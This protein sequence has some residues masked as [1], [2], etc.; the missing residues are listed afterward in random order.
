VRSESQV[1]AEPEPPAAP[2]PVI[3]RELRAGD[4]EAIADLHRR[5]Y[6]PEFGTNEMFVEGVAAAARSARAAGWPERGGGVWLVEHRGEL[7]GSL[8]LIAQPGDLGRV[9]WFVVHPALRGRGLGARMVAELV[10]LARAQDMRE[11]ELETFSELSAAARIY[12]G[13][14]FRVVAERPRDDWGKPMSYQRYHLR[15]S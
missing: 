8:A 7:G 12:R 5:V 4:V 9:R 3:R 13:H 1:S 6:T 14:G 2:E 11:L 10:E 15:L